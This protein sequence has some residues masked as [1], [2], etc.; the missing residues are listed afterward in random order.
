MTGEISLKG[1]AMAIGGLKEKSMAAYKAGCTTVIIP[2][3][4]MRDLDDISAEVKNA[5]KFV[6]VTTFE[7]IIPIALD[8]SLKQNNSK[9]ELIVNNKTTKPQVIT[10]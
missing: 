10:Q 6:P 3:D 4:N 5:V 9:N 8:G 2:E 1:K 7:Q